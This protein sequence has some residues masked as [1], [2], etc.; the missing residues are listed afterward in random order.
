MAAENERLQEKA[1]G[2]SPFAKESGFL[3]WNPDVSCDGYKPQTR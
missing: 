3:H 2:L 1:A